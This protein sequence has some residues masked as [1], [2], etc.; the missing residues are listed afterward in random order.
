MKSCTKTD[1]MLYKIDRY[2]KKVYWFESFSSG[3]KRLKTRQT[4]YSPFDSVLPGLLRSKLSPSLLMHGAFS[5]FRAERVRDRVRSPLS[6]ERSKPGDTESNG[7]ART[8]GRD[9]GPC[10]HGKKSEKLLWSPKWKFSK[11]IM[12]Y[13]DILQ[14]T[15]IH[16]FYSYLLIFSWK[17][18][19]RSNVSQ[20]ITKFT[21]H[22]Q[23][24]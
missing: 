11:S 5:S 1:E 23:K 15:C 20:N 3:I 17:F 14:F 2:L 19:S 13:E 9:W 6:V 22:C 7:N 24:R 21:I 12:I 18:R 4:S 8:E 16:I 10:G